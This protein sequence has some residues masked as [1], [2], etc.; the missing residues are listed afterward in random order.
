MRYRRPDARG[1]R[2]ALLLVGIAIVYPLTRFLLIPWF[3]ALA[4]PQPATAS[5]ANPALLVQAIGNSLR[6]GFETGLAAI[7]PGFAIAF[8]LERCAWRGN[9]SLAAGMWIVFL[10]PSYLLTTG[11]QI[12]MAAP[13][14]QGSGIAAVFY[15]E[16]GI[17]GLLAIK[18]L[19]FVSLTARA[20]WSMVGGEIGAAAQVHVRSPWRRFG[21]TA[22]LLGA[23]ASAAFAIVFVEA[24]GDFGV[25]AT[26]GAQI[27]LPLVTYDIYQRL[28]RTPVNF[29]AA[30]RLSLVLLA[31]AGGALSVHY[32][33]ARRA[34][35]V[36]SGRSRPA[37]RPHLG[38]FGAANAT[39]L[40][41]LVAFVAI[42]VPGLALFGQ[43]SVG[44]AATRLTLDDFASLGYSA[45]YAL[46]ASLAALLLATTLLRLN[47]G[48]GAISTQAMNAVTIGAMAVPGLVLGAAYV[49]AFNGWLPLYGSPW[50][51]VA[52]YVVGHLP[53]VMRLLEAPLRA[54][55]ASLG[56]AA[57]LHGLDWRTRVIR[58]H[59]PLLLR[60]LTWAWSVAF[61]SI[62]FELPL[63]A[64]LHPAGRAP[65]GVQLLTLDEGLH[66]AAEARLALAGA[67]VC[68]AVVALVTGVLPGWLTAPIREAR[69]VAPA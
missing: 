21:I 47:P 49:I 53:V 17:V 55:H 11:W 35:A 28:A 41:A 66:F 22:R 45:G 14:L 6:I 20:G 48:G 60:P 27:H 67:A 51:L 18:S 36:L 58:V 63:S 19:P 25:A 7:L 26:L 2:L 10:T 68:L 40:L 43:A 9:Q 16:A 30:A 15:S 37:S 39:V 5:T 31:M 64:L 65:L 62:F 32:L 3:P 69:R 44:D 12:L 4:P 24:I 59:L 8:L 38:Q 33:V 50:L 13:W 1:S 56:D 34:P 54:T 57:R 29:A 23:V 61:G 46:L 42:L 52:G